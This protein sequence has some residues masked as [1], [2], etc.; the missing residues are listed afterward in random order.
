MP[1]ALMSPSKRTKRSSIGFGSPR[2]MVSSRL[3]SPAITACSVNSSSL[4]NSPL[5]FDAFPP[6]SPANRASIH[7]MPSLDSSKFMSPTGDSFLRG[8]FH[9]LS[10]ESAAMLTPSPFRSHN[11]HQS[12]LARSSIGKD[13][14]SKSLDPFPCDLDASLNEIDSVWNDP[15]LNIMLKPSLDNLHDTPIHS[16]TARLET[17]QETIRELVF[18]APASEQAALVSVLASWARQVA[19]DP[20]G[21]AKRPATDQPRKNASSTA[22]V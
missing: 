19:R 14:E 2:S 20:L 17:L 4:C 22:Q 18:S 5:S 1:S 12:P 6:P 21:G 13:D 15:L 11:I 7:H 3:Q 16:L 9:P 8:G 10:S